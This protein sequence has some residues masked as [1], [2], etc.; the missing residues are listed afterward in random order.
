MEIIF[1]LD[2]TSSLNEF[3]RMINRRNVP[4]EIV[5]YNGRSSVAA[6]KK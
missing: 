6:N 1:R 5:I 2:T 3:S 4:F